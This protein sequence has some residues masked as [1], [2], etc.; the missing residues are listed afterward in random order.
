MPSAV[1]WSM[2]TK[3]LIS[4]YCRVHS[5]V[6]QKNMFLTMCMLTQNPLHLV[7]PDLEK[8]PKILMCF[9]WGIII[10]FLETTYYYCKSQHDTMH[11][12]YWHE[13]ARAK[14]IHVAMYVISAYKSWLVFPSSCCL[15]LEDA[16]SIFGLSTACLLTSYCPF[17]QCLS[18]HA[19]WDL[20]V[21]ILSPA[22]DT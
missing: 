4:I 12:Y 9:S 19:M 16:A 10:I 2:V 20:V 13:R 21:R 3:K 22:P 15:L 17:H 1:F 6:F 7:T 14:I 5:L 11:Y 18:L 8:N